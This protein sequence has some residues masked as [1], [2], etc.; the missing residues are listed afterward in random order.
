[1]EEV[2]LHP[3]IVPAAHLQ[4]A[5]V[6]LPG[7]DVNPAGHKVHALAPAV[8]EYV[9]AVQFMHALAPCTFEYAPAGH[10]THVSALFA[11]V[12]LEYVPAVQFMH[13]I[14]PNWPAG[15]TR[16]GHVYVS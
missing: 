12:T 3:I 15:Q 5:A 14:V 7:K 8:L 13:D 11:P 1:V 4:S 10:D 9:P 6:K 2:L 16:G